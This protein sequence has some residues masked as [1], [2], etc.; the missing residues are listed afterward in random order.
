MNVD[1]G[2]LR[3]FQ[4]LW[5][6]V[7][8]SIPAVIEAV[9]KKD[10]FDRGLAEQ[11]RAFEKAQSEVAKLYADADAHV[12]AAQAELERLKAEQAQFM[13]DASAKRAAENEVLAAQ[14]ADVKAKVDALNQKVAEA[15]ARV[16]AVNSEYAK[17]L[18]DA[19]AAHAAAVDA[20]ET[21]IKTLDERRV[22]AEKAL[23]A[24]RAKLG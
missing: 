17:R 22:K 3:K 18:A 2:A 4:D 9:A 12:A 8:D 24:L 20:M 6:P 23:E 21:E 15:Q 7:L 5:G 14:K 1:I 10:D 13:N 16:D 11:K 19:Q